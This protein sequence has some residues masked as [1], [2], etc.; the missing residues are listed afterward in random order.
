MINHQLLAHICKDA[1]EH[2]D[3]HLNSGTQ[4]TISRVCG[5]NVIAVR[6]TEKDFKDILTDLRAIP[7]WSKELGCFCHKG[8]LLSAREVL[9]IILKGRNL[10]GPIILTG[11]SL[12]GAIARI[13]G[14]M[15]KKNIPIVTFGEPRS[16][17]GQG[18]VN[19]LS[20]R[21]VNGMDCVPNHPWPIW[22]YR[23]QAPVTRIGRRR[24]KFTD[25][26]IADYIS[27]LS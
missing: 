9:Q 21:F 18:P 23:H 12:G 6:G 15:M 20:R 2:D 5:Y 10:N 13:L 8:F 4:G 1:Y 22:G 19:H 3:F 24:D 16:M 27:V 7:W 25:H 26:R 11:H 17:F 14:A